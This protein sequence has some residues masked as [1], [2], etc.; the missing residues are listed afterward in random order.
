MKKQLFLFTVSLLFSGLQLT[1]QNPL[2]THMYTADPTARVFNGK[3]YVFPSSDI[4]CE[5]GK[6]E[7][8]FCMPYYHAFS[9]EDLTTWEDHGKIIDQTEVPWGKKDGFGMWAP[10]C[11]EKD[12]VYYYYY[13]APPT[14]KSAF[15]R[16]GVATAN[17]P[18]GPYLLEN[19]YIKGVDG[20][21]PNVLIDDDG[22]AYLYYGGGKTLRVAELNADMKSIKGKPKVIETLPD[23]YKEGS[24][25]F[26]KDGVYYFTFP[27]DQSGSEEI[28]YAT[29]KNPMGPFE[30][31]GIIMDRFKDGIW[32]NHH[33]I[34]EYKNQWFIFYHHH[35]ISKNQ[36]L[37]SM[38][39]DSLFFDN[40]GKI[41]KKKA[42]L[43]GIGITKADKLVQIDRFSTSHNLKVSRLKDNN[44]VG[45]QLDYIK[46]GSFVTYN[47]VD[48][49]KNSP[50]KLSI[51]ASSGLQGG[52][53][54]VYVGN[55]LVST[56]KVTNTG[57]WNNWKEFEGTISGEIS[58]IKNIKLVF[59]GGDN[60]LMNVD[61][62]KFE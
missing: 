4:V 34:V 22:R 12:G 45:W 10:D 61:W 55:Y 62:I 46:N 19:D 32:T 1:A 49:G 26:K 54:K 17:D 2:V 57:N 42:T 38:R 24:F 31:Q 7:N 47:S 36:H 41:L 3:L 21:D 20:I 43:R 14:D 51:R 6:G 40:N 23:G 33:S 18:E 25:M 9:T 44:V 58:G 16:V 60:Y 48:F 15:R 29:G 8:G 52:N 5:D 30:Y 39:A 37:R 27:H 35:D 13:P 59:E 53:I 56:V 50:K 11:V 28:G